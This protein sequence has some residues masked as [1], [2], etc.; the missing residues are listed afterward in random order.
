MALLNSLRLSGNDGELVI[1]DRGLEHDQRARLEPFARIV[2]VPA[3]REGHPAILK[4]FAHLFDPKGVVVILDSDMLVVR[5]L[6]W[7]IERAAAG[8]IC[9]VPDPIP[10]RWRPEWADELRCASRCA[11]ART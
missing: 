7:V 6:G 8:G 11:A 2:E 4:P 9:L 5:D 10:D 1:L 3:E